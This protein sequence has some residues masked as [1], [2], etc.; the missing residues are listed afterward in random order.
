MTI[1]PPQTAPP[2]GVA[3]Q[4]VAQPVTDSH[5]QDAVFAA[6]LLLPCTVTARLRQ[7]SHP[8]HYSSA[9]HHRLHEGD[10]AGVA[11]AA[12]RGDLRAPPGHAVPVTDPYG[13]TGGGGRAAAG[14]ARGKV[15]V[16]GRRRDGE[17]HP[18]VVLGRQPDVEV[19]TER[20]GHFLCEEL[21]Q[22]SA[23]DPAYDLAH[24][25]P[26]GERVISGRA[27]RFPLQSLHGQTRRGG[28][29]VVE[30]LDRPVPV[31]QARSVREQV[32]HQHLFLA[33]RGEL[34]PVPADRCGQIEVATHRATTK[35]LMRRLGHS[36]PPCSTSTPPTT[37]TPTSPAPST[38]CWEHSTRRR[39]T[40]STSRSRGDWS[41][42]GHVG[43]FSRPN[44]PL[45]SADRAMDPPSKL[46]MR[47]RFPSPAPWID[48]G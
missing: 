24:E 45:T 17:R 7:Q 25:K 41:H 43:L 12:R 22:A 39:T 15:L 37:A 11:E 10:R 5:A 16:P 6:E 8:M 47:V 27:S 33:R 42:S 20:S 29:P 26:L 40:T 36:S 48:Q 14:R 4:P 44:M 19:R 9:G 31:G 30:I 2:K 38:P 28:R 13:G 21:A 32:P 34:R 3:E 18:V 23:G 1:E 35:E 46:A